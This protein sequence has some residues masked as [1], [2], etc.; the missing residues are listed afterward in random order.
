MSCQSKYMDLTSTFHA[1]YP[2]KSTKDL[3]NDAMDISK[4]QVTAK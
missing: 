2:R 4:N 1:Q 3:P